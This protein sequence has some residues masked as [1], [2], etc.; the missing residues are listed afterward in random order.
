MYGRPSKR[1]RRIKPVARVGAIDINV[2]YDIQQFQVNRKKATDECF[3]ILEGEVL[4]KVKAG[5]FYRDNS[6]HVLSCHEGQRDANGWSVAGVAVTGFSPRTDVYEQGFVL[7]ASGLTS[8]YNNS[9]KTINA[10]SD[11]YVKF[12]D[13]ADRQRNPN[14]VPRNK[15]LLRL[16]TI[17]AGGAVPVGAKFLGT[18]V[19]GGPSKGTI[20]VVLHKI[21]SST[22]VEVERVQAQNNA[23]GNGGLAGFANNPDGGAENPD[24]NNDF[25]FRPAG[26]AAP[27]RVKSKKGRSAK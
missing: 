3:D 6:L 13:K 22:F 10:G 12:G 25:Q 4:F 26:A 16:V 8:I 7:Q 1:F 17:P 11:V 5:N 14:G 19:K 27:K 24:N 20:D 9:D 21:A 2:R 18:C 15:K 23:N